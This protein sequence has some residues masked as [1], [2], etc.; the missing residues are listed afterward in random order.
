MQREVHISF[1]GWSW[2]NQWLC[3]TSK[4]E[5]GLH[6]SPERYRLIGD[7]HY[8]RKLVTY[9]LLPFLFFLLFVPSRLASLFPPPPHPLPLSL[10]FYGPFILG[11]ASRCRLSPWQQLR[12][13]LIGHFIKSQERQGKRG[14]RGG[15]REERVKGRNEWV[16]ET[17]VMCENGDSNWWITAITERE[18]E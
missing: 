13:D 17:R 16:K 10:Y 2:F 6:C 12:W 14:W 7:G 9:L 18:R 15:K 5:G 11:G 4:K 8:T 3:F 1:S